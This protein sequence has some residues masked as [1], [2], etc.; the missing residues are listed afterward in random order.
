MKA[1]IL[2][3]GVSRR[4]YPHTYAIPKCLLN[5]GGKPIIHYQLEALKSIG[6]MDIT[7]IVG[8]HR[9][10]L[11]SPKRKFSHSITIFV[12]NHHFFETNTAF[13]IHKGRSLDD[14]LILMN[15]DVVYT[16]EA[17]KLLIQNIKQL[18][19]LISSLA[20]GKKLKRLMEVLIGLLR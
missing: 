17:G 16:S 7:V 9:E 1:F 3:N 10:I 14:D 6:V 18:L 4:L 8:Y 13:S 19:P 5:V 11:K 15:A 20:E 2:A 12:I